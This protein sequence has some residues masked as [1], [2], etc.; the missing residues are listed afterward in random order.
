M[1]FA[2]LIYLFDRT[3]HVY[4]NYDTNQYLI[5]LAWTYLQH[6][7]DLAGLEICHIHLQ[8]KPHIK[9]P[10]RI[11]QL[12]YIFEVVPRVI[13]SPLASSIGSPQCLLP[14]SGWLTDWEFNSV[15]LRLPISTS[16]H[17]NFCTE[18]RESKRILDYHIKH[19]ETQNMNPT[20]WYCGEE[21]YV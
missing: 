14:E 13:M 3:Y 19:L 18:R 6:T 21:V 9:I 11:Y 17:F 10:Y 20:K 5:S 7:N 16:S 8:G 2:L 15:P 4:F 12:T 1:P